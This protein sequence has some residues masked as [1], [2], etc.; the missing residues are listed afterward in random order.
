MR[1]KRVGPA[2]LASPEIPSPDLGERIAWL[3]KRKGWGQAEL[4]RRIGVRANQIS[5]YE[6]GAYEPRPAVL[7]P[8]AEALET[9]VDYLLT[10]R[11]AKVQWDQRLRNLLP[12]LESLPEE[13]RDAVVFT[14]DALVRAHNLAEAHQ[15][16]TKARQA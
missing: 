6:R 13:L 10:G 2:S 4:A 1:E 3:R 9:T 5:K 14:L 11:E 8:L 7:G 16:R 15:K 12:L